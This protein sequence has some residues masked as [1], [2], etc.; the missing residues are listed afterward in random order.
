M[1]LYLFSIHNEYLDAQA[2]EWS[3]ATSPQTHTGNDEIC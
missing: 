3:C 2:H 1:I